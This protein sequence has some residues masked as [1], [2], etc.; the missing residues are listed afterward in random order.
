MKKIAVIGLFV[1]TGC[2][3]S[4]TAQTQNNIETAANRELAAWAQ[5]QQLYDSQCPHGSPEH[6]I[7]RERALES[8]QCYEDLARKIVLP[9]AI[10]PTEVSKLLIENK[11]AA[12]DYK[13]GALD[14]DEKALRVQE[15]WTNYVARMDTKA[16]N[17]LGMAQQQD[18]QLA[19]QRQLYFQNLSKQ[20]QQTELEQQKAL[21]QNT[22]QNTNCQ[23]IGNQ[24]QCTTW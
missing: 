11:R 8:N 6:P 21:Q 14:A 12:I 5:A 2:T 9:V 16:R 3:G 15:N 13:K 18:A 4:Y 1:L 7:A 22:P 23:L 10:D 17:A 24:M 19:Q 20:V